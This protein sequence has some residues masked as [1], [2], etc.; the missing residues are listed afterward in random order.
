MKEAIKSYYFSYK[1]VFDHNFQLVLDNFNVEAIHKMRTSVKRIRALYILVEHM[2]DKKFRAKKQLKNIRIL[3]KFGGRIRE[4]QI[5]RQLL[6]SYELKLDNKYPEYNEYL[7]KRE[8]R[9]IAKF[10]KNIPKNSDRETILN[11]EKFVRTID[12]FDEELIR[13][14]TRSFLDYKTRVIHNLINKPASN[15]RI[16][17]N[18]THLKQIYYL[19]DILLE[20]SGREVLLGIEN[21][22]LREIEKYF[23]TWHDL[24]NSPLYLN[25]FL[26]TKNAQP[27]RKYLALKRQISADRK[28]M[29]VE[30][31]S[32]LYPEILR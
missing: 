18:R 30:I 4:I 29:R 12:A 27:K 20:I 22:R 6:A 2:T 24:V 32:V 7:L 19:Y 16:H 8:R 15:E 17:S 3:F 5:E 1:E 9:E 28:K 13:E 31:L 11:N 10:L 25:A 21:T 14:K 23:G 26:K